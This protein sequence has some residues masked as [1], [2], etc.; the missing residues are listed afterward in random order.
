MSKRDDHANV[1][2]AVRY[3]EAVSRFAG[4]EE[5]ASFLH[6]DA[7]HT[8]LPN[9]LFPT[10]TVRGLSELVAAA[11]QGR[12]MLADQRFEVTSAVASGDRVALEAVWTG[13][14]AVPLGDLPAGHVLRAHVAAF[15]EFRDGRIIAQRNYD[16]YE[17]VS[18][19]SSD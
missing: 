4:P 9:I 12:T 18:P 19:G 13:T 7:V 8:Q 11:Q 17:P 1:R 6:P 2:T 10:G 15:L 16:C 14:L 3:H 5:L